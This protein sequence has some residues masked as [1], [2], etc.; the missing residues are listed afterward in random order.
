VVFGEGCAMAFLNEIIYALRPFSFNLSHHA[1]CIITPCS[2][3]IFISNKD[4][5]VARR[6]IVQGRGHTI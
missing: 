2:L 6:I 4:C 3:K 5:S 1:G